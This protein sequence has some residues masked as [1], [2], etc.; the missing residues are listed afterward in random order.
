MHSFSTHPPK[1][2]I[3]AGYSAQNV[4]QSFER[5]SCVEVFLARWCVSDYRA[6]DAIST[7]RNDV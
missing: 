1:V 3:G 4:G 5:L 2:E 7:A 6:Q